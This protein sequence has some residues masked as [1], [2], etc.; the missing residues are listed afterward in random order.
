MKKLM[1]PSKKK[2]KKP[3]KWWDLSFNEKRG[4]KQIAKRF[5][6]S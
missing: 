6:K 3:L 2:Q 4:I 5:D 1:K